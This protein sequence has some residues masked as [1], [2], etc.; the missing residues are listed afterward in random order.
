MNALR[1]LFYVQYLEGI[2]H[3]VRA[4]RIAE[5]LAARGAQITLVFGGEPVP[6]W[7]PPTAGNSCKVV[8]LP[9]LRASPES[10]SRLM[11]PDGTPA[12]AAYEARR[13]DRLLRAFDRVRPDV[14]MIEG[15]PFGRWAMEFELG[16]LLAHAAG[17]PAPRPL[18]LASLRDILQMPKSPAKAAR[19][20]AIY[21]RHFDGIL[22]HGDP[23]LVR[24][25]ESFPPVA[26]FLA[27]AHYT[28]IIAPAPPPPGTPPADGFDVIV[29]G[30][31]GA[32]ACPLLRAAI[33]AKPATSLRGA[34]W[35]A[36]TGPRMADGDWTRLTGAADAHEVTLERFR[37]GLPALMRG[38]RL[39]IQRAG[40][41][42]VGDLLVAGCRAVLVPDAD[43]GQREQPL[44]AARL[45]ALG[46]V[47]VA[48]EAE[49]SPAALAARIEAALAQ[50]V[51]RVALDL[52]G[53][54]RTAEI[55]GALFAAYQRRQP[56]AKDASGRRQ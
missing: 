9:P 47:T 53:A 16:P 3:V 1:V 8:Y 38:A 19:S 22:V 4:G 46:R 11:T 30:G 20:V 24:L 55:V 37:P 25:E 29:T 45:E 26:P 56:P 35:L 33:T 27:D 18:V 21:R 15:Y 13:R 41:N 7:A 54:R 48:D 10:Y 5:A 50:D 6:G 17:G 2:G 51:T 23:K 44:R 14:L 34:R 31:G 36:L 52:D 32:I 43:H 42:T 40:Y 39:S 49:L 28:G 12:N